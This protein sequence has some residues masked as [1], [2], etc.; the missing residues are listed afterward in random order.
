MSYNDPNS[1]EEIDKLASELQRFGLEESSR[2]ETPLPNKTFESLAFLQSQSPGPFGTLPGIPIVKPSEDLPVAASTSASSVSPLLSPH[3]PPPTLVFP[4]LPLSPP[5]SLSVPTSPPKPT[6]SLRKAK[7][8][9]TKIRV[10]KGLQNGK[11]DPKEFLEDLDWAYKQDH[12]A[13]EPSNDAEKSKY[14]MMTK[15][16][17]FRQNL[18]EDAYEWYSDLETEEKGDWGLLQDKF[19]ARYS[20]AVK[21]TLARKFEYRVMLGNLEQGD[22]ESIATYL[23]R[24][25][26]LGAKL[27][28][29]LVDV[30]MATLKGMRDIMKRQ[31]ISYTCNT[32]SDYSFKTVS[33]LI[34]A[35]YQEIGQRNSF[36]P[37]YEAMQVS[38][39]TASTTDQLLRQVLI[40][41]GQALPSILQ[42][43]RNLNTSSASGPQSSTQGAVQMRAPR[44]DLSEV[45]CFRCGEMGHYASVHD[46][47]DLPPITTTAA[48]VRRGNQSGSASDGPVQGN[49]VLTDDMYN[50][51]AV[52]IVTRGKRR[53]ADVSKPTK[54]GALH[55]VEEGQA[56]GQEKAKI[57]EVDSAESGA[58]DHVSD[59]EIIEEENVMDQDEM[60]QVTSPEA[61]STNNS[62]TRPAP[63]VAKTRVTKTGRV[64]ELVQPKRPRA[65]DPIRGM[66]GRPRFDVTKILDTEIFL[67]LGQLLDQS[68]LTVKELAYN[69]QRSTP[70]YRVRPKTGRRP[71]ISDNRMAMSA[72]TISPPVTTQA[73]E[74]D[75][76]SKPMMITSW[77]K[78]FKLPKTLLD[79]GSLV[80]LL[81]WMAMMKMR[82]QPRIFGD[83]NIQ[84]S[85]ANDSITTVTI[86][87]RG[88]TN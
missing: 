70:R 22:G 13:N 73:Y 80:E 31:Q 69:M 33:R 30:G 36:E 47:T 42:G 15:R 62:D 17:L 50:S 64:Q 52:G 6:A 68:D 12:Q 82:A 25:E 27:P 29:E 55:F 71:V 1:P 88:F 76:H 20:I 38:L 32:N 86:Q 41:T 61:K 53:E 85:L 19:L 84:I 77:V 7:M 67:T 45:R 78:H 58:E 46:W 54:A 65:V 21:D 14:E 43:L 18:E 39:P 8:G 56:S 28:N 34:K 63:T 35:A 81:S 24:A 51:K 3:S 26:Q 11:E 72:S 87:F 75:G 60:P 66:V 4:L 10:F 23:R 2:S 44:R 16:I 59:M 9:H 83:G 79:G 57:I 74:D 5:P 48:N 49:L 37:G 40:N